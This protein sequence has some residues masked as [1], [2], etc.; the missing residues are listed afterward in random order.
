M[1]RLCVQ[2]TAEVEYTCYMS[3]EDSRKIKE[4]AED[5]AEEYCGEMKDFFAQAAEELYNEGEIDPYK[6]STESDFRTE[7]FDHAWEEEG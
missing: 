4:R 1:S 3:D 6:Y 7:S 2:I 5:L